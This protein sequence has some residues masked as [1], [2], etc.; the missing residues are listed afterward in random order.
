MRVGWSEYPKGAQ[1]ARTGLSRLTSLRFR[2]RASR[3]IRRSRPRIRGHH[4]SILG[5]RF[6]RFGPADARMSRVTNSLELAWVARISSFVS[7]GSSKRQ[8]GAYPFFWGTHA[9]REA[10]SRAH[11]RSARRTS[12]TALPRCWARPE[13]PHPLSAVGLVESRNAWFSIARSIGRTGSFLL[14]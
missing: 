2:P 9:G 4:Q 1:P 7:T 13:S 12:S 3:R 8:N 6:V 11:R 5:P 14:P 10:G